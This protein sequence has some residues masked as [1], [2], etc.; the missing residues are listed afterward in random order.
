MIGLPSAFI[1][2]GIPAAL[3]IINKKKPAER[4]GK[5]SSSIG[6][7]NT[8]KVSI[9]INCETVI[10][11]ILWMSKMHFRKKKGISK[12]SICRTFERMIIT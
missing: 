6:N 1:G 9:E 8:Q 3:L 10:S 4:K 2:T 5:F 12:L 11:S 7:L